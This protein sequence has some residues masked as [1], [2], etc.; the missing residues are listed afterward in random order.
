MHV[1]P[2]TMDDRTIKKKSYQSTRVHYDNDCNDITYCICFL[3][4][5][6]TFKQFHFVFG[7]FFKTRLIRILIG[8]LILFRVVGLT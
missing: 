6:K 3:I 1:V 4:E 2:I 5:G 8:V 7:N